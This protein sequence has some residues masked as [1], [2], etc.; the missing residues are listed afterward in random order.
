M[1]DPRHSAVEERLVLLGISERRRLLAVM[2]IERTKAV[3]ILAPGRPHVRREEI[4]KKSPVKAC[5]LSVST[6][7]RFSRS[8]TSS[9][10]RPT[11]SHPGTL[12]EAPLWCWNPMSPPPFP[13]QGKQMRPCAHWRE[14][15]RNTVTAGQFHGGA[16]RRRHDPAADSPRSTL[17]LTWTSQ[18]VSRKRAATSRLEGADPASF[19]GPRLGDRSATQWYR[20]PHVGTAALYANAVSTN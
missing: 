1:A 2:Y 19:L 4:M 15:Y 18:R 3:R 12:R 9:A 17:P 14:S 20:D 10:A 16:F 7:T 13:V 6:P 11:S 8:M 5:P